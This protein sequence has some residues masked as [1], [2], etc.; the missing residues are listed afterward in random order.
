MSFQS[1]LHARS[2]RGVRFVAAW[3]IAGTVTVAP[4]AAE[5]WPTRVDASYRVAFSGFDV[6]KF[7]F[8]ADVNGSSY[9][10][11]GDAKL[12]ALLGAFKWEGLTRSSG[13]LAGLSPKPAG[14]T[15]DFKGVGKEG[16]IKLGFQHGAV[17][18]VSAMPPK[19]P[20]PGTI[21]VREQHLK[22]VLDPLSAV[23]A[24]SRTTNANP[25]GRKLSIFDGKQRFDLVLTYV[26]QQA[27]AEQK[28]SGQPGVAF[29]CRVRYVPIAGYVMNE[30]TRHM[31]STEGIEVALRPVPS[32][33]IFVPHQITIPTAAGNATLTAEQVNIVT[34]G[35]QIA[36]SN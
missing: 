33:A 32:A 19:P 31:A 2:N 34:R 10:V 28:P 20:A 9:T 26:R 21:P 1:K 16:S 4:A 14:Y 17:T 27:V 35:E 12:S 11:R 25:C 7:D 30:E 15:F 24:M 23:M 13:A 36:F 5:G 22:D 6:G 3:L 18:S 29:V 8:S